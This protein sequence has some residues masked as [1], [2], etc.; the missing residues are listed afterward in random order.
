MMMKKGKARLKYI[1]SAIVVLLLTYF[2]WSRVLKLCFIGEGAVYL[3]E[4][5][6]S[7]FKYGVKDLLLRYD[8]L[9]LI[10]FPLVAPIFKDN[11]FYYMLMLLVGVAA[12]NLS[13][14][15]VV[16]GITKKWLIAFLTMIFF[17]ANYVGSFEGL[18]QGIYPWFIQRIPNFALAFTSFY[19]TYKFYE[20]NKTKYYLISLFTYSLSMLLASYSFFIF[21]FLLFYPYLFAL[22]NI[23]KRKWM[24]LI[25]TTLQ[26]VPYAVV[27]LY[28]VSNQGLQG[29]EQA[30]SPF[31]FGRK[32][33]FEELLREITVLTIPPD[34]VKHLFNRYFD[35]KTIF[36]ILTIPVITIYVVLS[37]LYFRDKKENQNKVFLLTIIL[38]LLSTTFFA[39]YLN[40]Y[41][42]NCYDSWRYLYTSSAFLA[43]FQGVLLT[44]FFKK[45]RILKVFVFTVVVAWFFY[46]W[47]LIQ[48]NISIAIERSDKILVII[49]YIRDNKNTIPDKST[50]I[51]PPHVGG[52]NAGMFELFYSPRIKFELSNT[53]N[54]IIIK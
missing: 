22:F 50:I 20:S 24:H 3:N 28:F 38:S 7:M 10:V 27:S 42:V 52:Y 54:N 51:L 4:P 5:Q 2:V 1:I 12:V 49:N 13:L 17:I 35:I 46:N 16:W 33:L 11:M 6:Y 9:A 43:I 53:G 41:Y 30:L 48:K 21:P 31:I 25:T 32:T 37:T 29:N 23:K 15:F 44:W 18:G 34:L 39:I 19:F 8:T 36:Q 47:F 26:I 40:P 14:F 45:N